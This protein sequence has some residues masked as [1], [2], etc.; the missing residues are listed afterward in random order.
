MLHYAITRV[1]RIGFCTALQLLCCNGDLV[2]MNIIIPNRL[3][4]EILGDNVSADPSF[5]L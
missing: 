5:E 3:K 4:T 2:K 1:A